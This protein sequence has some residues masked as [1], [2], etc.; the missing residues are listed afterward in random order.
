MDCICTHQDGLISRKGVKDEVIKMIDLIVCGREDGVFE[1]EL[2]LFIGLINVW[3]N[4]GTGRTDRI[5][6]ESTQG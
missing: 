6:Q 1:E 5:L 3:I 2:V 4:S